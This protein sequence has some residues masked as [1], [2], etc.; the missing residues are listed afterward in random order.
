M[1]RADSW[2]C[3]G[4]QPAEFSLHGRIERYSNQSTSVLMSQLPGATSWSCVQTPSIYNSLENLLTRFGTSGCLLLPVPE[5]AR[6]YGIVI[7][8]NFGD[9]PPPHFHAEYGGSRALFEIDSFSILRGRLSP[10]ARGLIVEWAALH[11]AELREAWSRASNLE[12]PRKIPPL[13]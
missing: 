3:L 2:T 8:M 5:L 4:S 6:F 1:A 9:H 7:R 10:R 12:S 11:Q 13:D